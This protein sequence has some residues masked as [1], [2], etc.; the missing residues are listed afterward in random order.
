MSLVMG[1]GPLEENETTA[2]AKSFLAPMLFNIVA[3][4]SLKKFPGTEMFIVSI[5]RLD[6][7]Y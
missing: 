4:G 2:G 1:L 5:I 3:V 6:F 7:Y